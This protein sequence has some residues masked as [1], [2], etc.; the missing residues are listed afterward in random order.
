MADAE[1]ILRDLLEPILPKLDFDH[2][3]IQVK[4]INSG[5]ANYTSSLYLVTVKNGQKQLDM[6]AKVGCIGETMRA[7]MNAKRLYK[8][9]ALVYN[10]LA[11]IYEE[12]QEKNG[13]V[14]DDKFVFPKFYGC[15][16]TFLEEAV[17]L[18]NLVAKGYRIFNRFDSIDWEH[19]VSAVKSMA[20]FHALSFAF[21]HERPEEFAEVASQVEFEMHEPSE[22]LKELW[23]QMIKRTLG[24]VDKQ[25]HGPIVKFFE[26]GG[27]DLFKKFSSP[28][29]KTVLIHADYRPSNLMFKTEV[30][31]IQIKQFKS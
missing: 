6:F 15:N 11:K 19:A 4:A 22:Q 7:N 1:K 21:Q 2:H 23:G 16:E 13:I 25:Y 17:V 26:E 31:V 5:G 8:T 20:Q 28:I 14:G 10:K 18:E 27:E 9:E 12:L 24:V 29:G 3:E 30:S